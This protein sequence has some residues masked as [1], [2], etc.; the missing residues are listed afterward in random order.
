MTKEEFLNLVYVAYSSAIKAK[1]ESKQKLEYFSKMNIDEEESKKA[2]RLYDVANINIKKLREIIMFPLYEKIKQLTNQELENYRQQ[3]IVDE[4]NVL[5]ENKNLLEDFQ[6]QLEELVS[7][8]N[9]NYTLYSSET[10]E[11]KKNILLDEGNSIQIKINSLKININEKKISL[12]N[13]QNNIY[14]LQRKSIT[15][16]REEI[17]SK[18]DITKMQE[19][20]EIKHITSDE[21][22]KVANSSGDVE[23]LLELLQEYKKINNIMYGYKIVLPS[24]EIA[25]YLNYLNKDKPMIDNCILSI[26]N[27]S[28]MY[29]LDNLLKSKSEHVNWRLKNIKNEYQPNF[30]NIQFVLENLENILDL[31][32]EAFKSK[33]ELIM[34]KNPKLSYRI[35]N[36]LNSLIELNTFIGRSF[37][38]KQIEEY[39]KEI[40]NN[41]Y[42]FIIDQLEESLRILN[43]CV[44]D[45]GFENKIN[46]EETFNSEYL[47]K[48]LNNLSKENCMNIVLM[49]ND[50]LDSI[51]K[52]FEQLSYDL[53]FIKS[54]ADKNNH[55]LKLQLNKKQYKLEDI[56]KKINMLI[57]TKMSP[58]DLENLLKTYSAEDLVENLAK[59]EFLQV[60]NEVHNHAYSQK[61]EIKDLY[62]FND[63]FIFD[64][65]EMQDEVKKV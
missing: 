59:V 28:D 45:I 18:L 61:I 62:E 50:N 33:I 23:S 26:Q 49:V 36:M 55:E 43:N 63:N 2:Q 27:F 34:E 42:E 31:D 17:F 5:K 38:G 47:M 44:K 8:Q 48:C 65:E 15:D 10:D 1:K 21:V 24:E 25:I 57:G 60:L 39:K 13:I 19:N 32:I 4:T 20:E 29:S 35:S 58:S 56:N 6:L 12:E 54:E 37:K 41:V 51:Y 64:D 14:E 46:N 22:I 30:K 9:E 11:E 40:V 7:A 52:L 53:N 16:I 3:L